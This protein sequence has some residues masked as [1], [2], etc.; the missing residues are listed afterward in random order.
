M[1]I[2]SYLEKQNISLILRGKIIAEYEERVWKSKKTY[3]EKFINEISV[4]M[5]KK[6]NETQ[7]MHEANRFMPRFIRRAEV[8]QQG[9]NELIS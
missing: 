3:K 9:F 5:A 2:S 6:Y 1:K 4:N 7:F 8:S